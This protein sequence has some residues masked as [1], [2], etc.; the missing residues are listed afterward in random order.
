MQQDG[1]VDPSDVVWFSSSSY[2]NHECSIFEP[3]TFLRSEKCDNAALLWLLL[4]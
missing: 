4:L 3:T 2:S 1:C